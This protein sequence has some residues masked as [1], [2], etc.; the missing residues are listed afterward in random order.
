MTNIER[1]TEPKCPIETARLAKDLRNASLVIRHL[2]FNQ[3]ASVLVGLLWCMALVAVIVVGVLHSARL[4]LMVGK[5]YSDKIQARYLALAGIEKARALLYRDAVER[6]QA[7]KNHTG[8]LYDSPG[9]FREIK[10][11]PGTFSII[12]QG[13][14][15]EGGGIF[16]GISD[17]ESR[18]NVNEAKSEELTKINGLTPDVVAAITDWKDEDNNVSPGGAE[19]EYYTTLRPPYVPRNGPLLTVRE[20]LMVRGISPELLLGSDMMQNQ[21]T[22]N[23]PVPMEEGLWNYLTVD[24][25]TQN[26]NA[27]G[28]TRVNIQTADEATLTAVHGITRE[29]AQAIVTYRNDKKLENLADLLEVTAPRTGRG[30]RT[31][32]AANAAGPLVINQELFLEI[33]DSL[34]AETVSEQRG[35]L[36]INTVS[37]QVLGWLPGI[38]PELAG[39]IISYRNSNGFFPNIAWLLKVPGMSRDLFK[40]LAGR[41]TARSETF[42]IVSEGAIASSGVRQRVEA[43]VHVSS[44]DVITLAWREDL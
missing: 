42:R 2:S 36:N 43:V 26:V 23:G 17:E 28:D 29:I 39:E 15:V 9:E 14:T 30:R 12:R 7:D 13:R 5:N 16:F 20:L 38:T 10:L 1:M 34:S 31:G 21:S 32:S 33:A 37:A 41:V 3:S 19:A 35:L 44:R 40:Q 8:E 18:L 24:G 6:R 27:K 11:G 4:H 22:A 25:W